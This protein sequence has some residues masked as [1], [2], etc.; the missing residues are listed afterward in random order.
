MFS[1]IMHIIIIAAPI[2]PMLLSFYPEKK[3]EIKAVRMG[4]VAL[5]H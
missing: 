1:A 5:K 4:W 2:I 3:Y